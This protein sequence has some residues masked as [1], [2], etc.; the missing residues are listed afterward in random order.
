MLTLACTY[1][2][3]HPSDLGYQVMADAIFK[4]SGYQRLL[5]GET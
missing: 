4:V 5:D 2:D 3:S 1:G